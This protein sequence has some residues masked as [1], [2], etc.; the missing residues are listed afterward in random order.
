[1][2]RSLLQSIDT[3][4]AI[5]KAKIMK[6]ELQEMNKDMLLYDLQLRSMNKTYRRILMKDEPV[7]SGMNAIK[8]L[9]NKENYV[10]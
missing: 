8:Q 10:V 1:M 6:K 9:K 3:N 4:I 2:E 5:Q 7:G